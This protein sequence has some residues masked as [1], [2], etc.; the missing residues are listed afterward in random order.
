MTLLMGLRSRKPRRYNAAPLSGTVGS[1]PAVGGVTTGDK[2]ANF[3]TGSDSNP[4]TQASPYKTIQKLYDN[5][6]AGQTGV[7]R[8][9]TYTATSGTTVLNAAVG[10]GGTSGSP[11]RIAA[12]QGET[13]IVR[14]D[15]TI[16][17]SYVTLNGLVI[18]HTLSTDKV[19]FE[20]A[21]ASGV[22]TTGVIVE[23]CEID[24]QNRDCNGI[25]FGYQDGNARAVD[26]VVRRC[27]IRNIA[28]QSLI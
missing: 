19:P 24:G 15:I 20:I 22:N 11:K 26:C 1:G 2:W 13:V 25:M 8:A 4:G 12:Y 28:D 27:L 3:A 16:N 18:Q 10:T 9:G 6:A 23:Y 5:L 17:A 21:R 14:N 7:L